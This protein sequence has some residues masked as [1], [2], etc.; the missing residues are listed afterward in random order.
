M[1]QEFTNGAL[2]VPRDADH[3][4]VSSNVASTIDTFSGDGQFPGDLT[5]R[6]FATSTDN[7]LSY[8]SNLKFG[9]REFL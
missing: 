1:P 5:F 6:S 9:V 8:R 3:G 7:A 4:N 2:P